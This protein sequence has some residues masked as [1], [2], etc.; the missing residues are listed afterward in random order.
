MPSTR[1]PLTHPHLRPVPQHSDRAVTPPPLGG[2]PARITVRAWERPEVRGRLHDLRGDYV[3]RFWLGVLGPSV[4]L[5]LRR[6]DRG[7]DHH[8]EGFAIDLADTARA[9]G[10][11][12]STARNSPMART[13]E[14]A[15]MFSTMRR[16]A[17]DQYELRRGL[18]MLN[19]RQLSRLPAVVRNAH[20]RWVESQSTAPRPP[21]A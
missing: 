21:A 12:A 14:R 4:T 17:V 19:E 18:P 9:I 6:L 13:L 8:P 20:D 5:L 16:T 11:G 3:E 15:C 2:P 7:F 1:P 10:L